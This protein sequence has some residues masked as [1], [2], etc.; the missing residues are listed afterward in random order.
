VITNPGC[1]RR[2]IPMVSLFF[3]QLIFYLMVAYLMGQLFGLL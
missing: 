3:D 1:G 2:L